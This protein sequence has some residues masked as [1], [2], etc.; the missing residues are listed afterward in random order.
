M[1]AACE[2]MLERVR[3]FDLP[4][5]NEGPGKPILLKRQRKREK[6]PTWWF[7]F[8]FNFHIELGTIPILTNIF[9]MG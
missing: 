7:Q 1:L 8:F 3:F 5:K 2:L 4:E 9:Q 6:Q